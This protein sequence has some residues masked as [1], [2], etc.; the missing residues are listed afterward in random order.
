[1]SKDY[2]TASDAGF[3]GAVLFGT[4]AGALDTDPAGEYPLMARSRISL[5]QFLASPATE[6]A[7]R[8]GTADRLGLG[9]HPDSRRTWWS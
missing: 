5:R 4:D 7:R 1:L 3:G 6:P 8:R 2:R 9:T